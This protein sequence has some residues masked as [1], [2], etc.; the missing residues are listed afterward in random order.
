M[1]LRQISYRRAMAFSSVMPHLNRIFPSS[2]RARAGAFSALPPFSR[3]MER[4]LSMMAVYCSRASL[5][6]RLGSLANSTL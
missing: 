4:A 1:W 2:S 6:V 5:P 3:M